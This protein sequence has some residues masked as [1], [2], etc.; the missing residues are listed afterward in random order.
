MINWELSWIDY[1]SMVE[2]LVVQFPTSFH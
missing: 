2:H 1:S